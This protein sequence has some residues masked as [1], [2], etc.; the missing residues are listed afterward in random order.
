MM[1]TWRFYGCAVLAVC[2]L[3]AGVTARA[4]DGAPAGMRRIVFYAPHWLTESY[5]IDTKAFTSTEPPV[6]KVLD[7]KAITYNISYEDPANLGFN[8]PVEGAKRRTRLEEALRYVGDVVRLNGNLDVRV[9]P[10]L[11][12]NTGPLASAGT[13][14]STAPSFTNGSAFERLSTGSKPFGGFP[15]IR[16][17][18]NFGYNWNFELSSPANNQFDFLSVMVHEITHGIGFASLASPTGASVIST[19]VYSHIDRLMIRNT[20]N[21]ALFGGTPPAFLG[22]EADL[23]SNDL[24]FT[25][26][27]AFS[28]Y[29]QGVNAGIFAPNPFSSGSSLSHWDTGNIVGGAVMEHAIRQGVNRRQFTN[30]EL[31]ALRDMGFTSAAQADPPGGNTGP[32]EGDISV[33]VTVNLRDDDTGAPVTT[34]SVRLDPG[35]RTVTDNVN[36]AYRFTITTAGTFRV[37]ATAS[38]FRAAQSTNFTITAASN[39]LNL[40]LEMEPF[41]PATVTVSPSSSVNYGAVQVGQAIERNFQVTNTGGGILTGGATVSGSGFTV[42]GRS[43]YSLGTGERFTI[44]V[45]FA[46]GTAADFSGTV[47]FTGSSSTVAVPLSGAGEST[48]PP[49]PPPPPPNND[50]CGCASLARDGGAPPTGSALLLAAVA[51]LMLLADWRRRQ[52][53]RVAARHGSTPAWHPLRAAE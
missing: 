35:A 52:R 40:N 11:F 1:Q 53:A 48:A 27:N 44:S 31:G 29:A 46:P 41:P 39:A 49:P 15:E 43:T 7:A 36:G 19:G 22:T 3:F 38:G 17:I 42:L 34:A 2:L 16:I 45:R 30:L 37:A 50:D 51:A 5:Y 4:D 8:D 28:R 6:R 26:T 25:G 23:R 24:A 32:G 20:G 14:Y 47:T 9:E 10:S 18:C 33:V 21:R 12:N 13:F